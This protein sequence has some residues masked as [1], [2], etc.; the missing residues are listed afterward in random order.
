MGPDRAR[1]DR[2]GPD[3]DRPDPALPDMGRAEPELRAEPRV[4]QDRVPPVVP[5]GRA[6][7]VP[8]PVKQAQVPQAVP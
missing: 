6:G 4:P 1:V 3:R 2:V 7:R 5:H 8:L